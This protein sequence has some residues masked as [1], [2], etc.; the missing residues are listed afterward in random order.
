[1]TRHIMHEA[2]VGRLP[3]LIDDE[4]ERRSQ[5]I[6]KLPGLTDDDLAAELARGVS[7][8]SRGS[9]EDMLAL[10]SAEVRRRRRR[11]HAV[12]DDEDSDVC[13][14]G[15]CGVTFADTIAFDRHRL[16]GRCADPAERGL[17]PLWS[18]WKW[19]R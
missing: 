8:N 15:S 2:D 14:C 7:Y 13:R 6:D 4:Q 5:Y 17:V 1:M 10:V 16:R 3:D 11:R 9:H 18:G 12:P 19:L